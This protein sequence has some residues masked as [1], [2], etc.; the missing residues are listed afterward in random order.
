M[1]SEKEFDNWR[2]ESCDKNMPK[3]ELVGHLKEHGI[4]TASGTRSMLSHADGRDFFEWRFEWDIGGLK[5]F[6]HTR[7]LRRG[8]DKRAWRDM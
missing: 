3:S 2:C 6:Q 1:S 8:A 7:S 4:T 5:F